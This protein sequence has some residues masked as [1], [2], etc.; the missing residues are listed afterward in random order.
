MLRVKLKSSLIELLIFLPCLISLSGEIKS[1]VLFIS[2]PFISSFSKDA[3]VCQD[4]HLN[5][6]L[7]FITG[8]MTNNTAFLVKTIISK[9]Q[10]KLN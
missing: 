10:K 4:S 1:L 2:G 9:S 5:R 3:W 6:Y 8:E 7:E